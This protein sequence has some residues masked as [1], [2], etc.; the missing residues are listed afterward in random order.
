MHVHMHMHM[1]MHMH[2]HVHMHMHMHTLAFSLSF[3]SALSLCTCLRAHAHKAADSVN[4]TRQAESVH[5]GITA[6]GR[7]HAR[8]HIDRRG[9][10][11]PIVL[12]HRHVHTH[13]HTHTHMRDGESCTCA[14]TRGGVGGWVV[15]TPRSASTRESS[16]TKQS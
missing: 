7:K 12:S 16:A 10:A 9:L 6:C 2:M 15:R 11:R 1:Y 14:G 5:I 13:V 8:E 4:A 3:S